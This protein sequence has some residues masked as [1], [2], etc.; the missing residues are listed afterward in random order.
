[1]STS[2]EWGV[3]VVMPVYN[4]ARYLIEAIQSILAQTEAPRE[5]ILVDDGSTDDSPALIQRAA[6]SAPI[7]LRYT[8]QVNQGTAAARNRGIELAA[9]PLIAFLDQDDLWLPEKLARQC[10]LLRRQPAAGYSI[11]QV[12][13]FIDNGEPPPAWLRA[14]WLAGPQPVYLPSGLLVRRSTFQQVGVFDPMLR[15]GSDIDWFARVRSAGVAVAVAAEILVRYRVHSSNQS[16]FVRENQHDLY[17]VARKAIQ[18]KRSP[19]AV[20]ME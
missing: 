2:D 1:M 9:S 10:D 20:S 7:P 17:E 5:I 19:D 4:G 18:R 11:T 12:E 3:S 16:Q 8:A 6:A 15:N 13:S 14:G